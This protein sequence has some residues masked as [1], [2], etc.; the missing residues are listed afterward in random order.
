MSGNDTNVSFNFTEG[1]V[2]NS[3]LYEL[4]A[5][6]QKQF[7]DWFLEGKAKGSTQQQIGESIGWSREKVKDI[8]KLETSIGADILN[9]AKEHQEGRAPSIGASAPFNFTEGWFRN[10]GLY[11]LKAESQ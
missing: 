4:K 11:E 7:M 5:D 6:R 9:L 10:S 3:G 8:V 1:W 2:R